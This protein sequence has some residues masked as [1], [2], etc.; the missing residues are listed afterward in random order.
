MKEN[1]LIIEDSNPITPYIEKTLEEDY[2]VFV[3]KTF[4]IVVEYLSK[5]NFALV[6]MDQIFEDFY[7][8]KLSFKSPIL[9]L[10]DNK[11]DELAE[12][13]RYCIQKPFSF[14]TLL[15]KI[16]EI[17]NDKLTGTQYLGIDNLSLDTIN[18]IAFRGS[19]PI[20]LTKKEYTLLLFL[21]KN[22]NKAVPRADLIENV[23][24][25]QIDPFSNTVEA[26]I[27]SLRKKIDRNHKIKLIHTIPKFGY[28]VSVDK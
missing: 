14:I 22:K 26:H 21:V 6:I 27:F 3:G 18:R 10:C 4:D 2:V 16:G 12:L 1:I 20:T 25:M 19:K 24:G 5:N 11:I 15:Y 28:R 13:K 17:I 9:L 8:D 7:K 23:W